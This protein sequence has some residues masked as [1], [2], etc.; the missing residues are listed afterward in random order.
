MI[1]SGENI[2]KVAVGSAAHMTGVTDIPRMGQLPCQCHVFTFKS[3]TVDGNAIFT[4][5]E[6][7]A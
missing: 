3:L 4:G 1:G 6:M 5:A 7:I 2:F